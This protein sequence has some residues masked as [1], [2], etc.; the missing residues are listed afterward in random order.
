MVITHGIYVTIVSILLCAYLNTV[1][2][3]QFKKI[4]VEKRIGFKQ[5]EL[6]STLRASNHDADDLIR[7]DDLVY[8]KADEPLFSINY[9]PLE[10]P[11]Q[12]T[13]ERD[14]EDKLLERSLRFYDKSTIR[15][16]ETCY[17]VGLEDRSSF[18]S[19]SSSTSPSSNKQDGDSDNQED[20]DI[21]YENDSMMFEISNDNND[22]EFF[23]LNNQPSS[24]TLPTSSS[25]N[26]K[27]TNTLKDDISVK[28][29]L[30]ESLTELSELAGAAGLTVVGS[31]Y[32]RYVTCNILYM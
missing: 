17:L 14:L 5:S 22:E 24:I 2:S 25:S 32:Q 23:S 9:D 11:T 26:L 3:Y 1:L 29:T 31:T 16:E 4:N 7:D 15:K 12:A 10:P 28:Y 30:E 19:S 13:Y 8:S 18:Y 21:D 20:F 27:S 6:S